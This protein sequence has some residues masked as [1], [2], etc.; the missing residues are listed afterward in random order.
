MDVR[1]K[2]FNGVQELEKIEKGDWVDLRCSGVTKIVVDNFITEIDGEN[3]L[4]R[5]VNKLVLPK[6]AGT[7]MNGLETSYVEFFRYKK[8]DFLM[9]DLGIAMELPIGCEAH[10]LP[11]SS[12]Y[13]TFS[14]LETNGMGIIDES[15]KG[16]GDKWFMPVIAMEDG[17]ILFNERVA[18]FSI[19]EKMCEP[20]FKKVNFLSNENRGGFGSTGNK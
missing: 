1:V 19:V 7:F 3:I 8:G 16:D 17:F 20:T 15:Y 6:E 4:T 11:R 9:I 10:V 12:A 5:N 14:I 13:K 2:Y 18:Q